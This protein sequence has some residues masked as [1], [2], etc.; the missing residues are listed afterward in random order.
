MMMRPV[1]PGRHGVAAVLVL[2]ATVLL[3]S[4]TAVFTAGPE[5]SA[6]PLPQAS[7]RA[8]EGVAELATI[9]QYCLGC[10]NDRAR[11]ADVSFEGITAASV[12]EH[13]ELFEKAVRKLRGRVMPPPGSRQPESA[14]VD[15]VVAWLKREAGM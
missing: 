9:Q 13:A 10:H 14:A 7:A 5:G 3:A 6:P 15:A 12:G 2:A 11:V 4:W 1:V 8:P